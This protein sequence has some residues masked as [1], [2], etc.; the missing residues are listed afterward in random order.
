MVRGRWYGVGNRVPLNNVKS[1]PL[2][3]RHKLP[4]GSFGI[5]L[6]DVVAALLAIGR[7]VTEDV[8]RDDPTPDDQSTLIVFCPDDDMSA[9]K[10]ATPVWKIGD[11]VRAASPF[12]SILVRHNSVETRWIASPKA[13][14]RTIR[15]GNRSSKEQ[16]LRKP[17]P[18]RLAR[19]RRFR[20]LSFR[21]ARPR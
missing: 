1:H 7:S 15:L 8:K 21:L 6:V 18:A 16:I 12:R 14:Q 17:R 19:L 5:E 3:S 10:V 4:F 9:G 13:I 20:L 2:Q 11:V